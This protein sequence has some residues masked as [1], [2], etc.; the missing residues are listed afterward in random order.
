MYKPKV[1]DIVAP[2]TKPDS[3][4]IV[5]CVYEYG[6]DYR[7]AGQEGYCKRVDYSQVILVKGGT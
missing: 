7:I 4:R 1:G 6:F 2:K 5:T 3:H